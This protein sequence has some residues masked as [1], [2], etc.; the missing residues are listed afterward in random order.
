MLRLF[1]LLAL[2]PA[3]AAIVQAQANSPGASFA[4]PQAAE[5]ANT[6]EDEVYKAGTEALNNGDYD[7]A[8]SHF[9]Q[10]A[11]LH[12]RRAAAALYWKGYAFYKA[13]NKDQA[14]A[15]FADLKKSY[16]ESRYVQD[17][18]AIEAETQGAAASPDQLSSDEEKLIALQIL[19]RNDPDKAVPY[20]VKWLHSTPSTKTQDK[21]LFI[22]SQCGS[23]KAQQA[24]VDVAK[25]NSNPDL[26]KRAIR[27][28]GMNGSGH[29]RAALKEI[30]TSAASVEVKKA[31]FQGWLMSGD[32]ESVLSVAKQEKSPEL[33]KE[34]IH[35]L[36]I[37]GG[38]GEL[39]ELYKQTDDTSTKLSLLQAMGIG[40]DV[41]GMT[42][43]AQNDKDPEIRRHA[44]KNLGIFGGHRASATL[45]SIYNSQADLGTK[46]E[47]INA[48]F[49]SQS[50]K[51]L[52]ALARKETD[53]EL[54]KAL[55]Q[56]MS[57]MSSPEITEYMMEILNK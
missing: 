37:M 40:G 19:V 50:A 38:R 31:V 34:A 51:E 33:R 48:L 44:V 32:K 17:A 12:G 3:T 42:E 52:V 45:V 2:G 53:P 56:K 41:E 1:F 15:A 8:V 28:L 23:D 10:V 49:L 18:R 43:I 46:K 6:H 9:D 29:G 20:A 21:I 55:V 57:L 4:E 27:Y 54:K 16:P 14:L 22:L 47:V 13:G 7:S 26:Q 11:K 35:Y 36:G 25:D 30:Y 5:K 39:R 24:L